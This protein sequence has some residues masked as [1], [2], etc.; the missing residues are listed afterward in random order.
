MV[1]K[2]FKHDLIG[3]ISTCL[4][5][6]GQLVSL[7]HG[8]ELTRRTNLSFCLCRTSWLTLSWLLWVPLASA[9]SK[10]QHS[11]VED[12]FAN[13]SG[14]STPKLAPFHY[15]WT[16]RF[17]GSFSAVVQR[18][19]AVKSIISHHVIQT[20]CLCRMGT[21]LRGLQSQSGL[22]H[23]TQIPTPERFSSQRPCSQ[24]ILCDRQSELT[25]LEGFEGS[26]LRSLQDHSGGRWQA[27]I[28]LMLKCIS[29]GI[30]ICPLTRKDLF[31][32]SSQ[33]FWG[34]LCWPDTWR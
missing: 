33:C 34:L 11:L 3:V 29:S 19:T 6:T 8:G 12:S 2:K 10:L 14:K 31:L 15:N 25:F 27:Q 5:S 17:H 1:N 26:E 16:M 32:C 7:T 13:G 21:A 22:Q 30:I 4:V 20:R 28:L 23:T 9:D 24:M 18:H